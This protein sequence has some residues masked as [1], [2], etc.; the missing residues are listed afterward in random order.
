MED[1][2]YIIPNKKPKLPERIQYDTN[3]TEAWDNLEAAFKQVEDAVEE[4]LES[5]IP[6]K[7]LN[8]ELE[9]ILKA[10]INNDGKMMPMQIQAV[11]NY[12]GWE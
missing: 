7:A 6:M 1:P 3:L 5:M 4:R 9:S 10:T 11:K 2:D 8:R 12:F